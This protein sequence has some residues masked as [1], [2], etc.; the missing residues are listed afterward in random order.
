M[1]SLEDFKFAS[2]ERKCDVVT[3]EADYIMM[4]KL[5]NCKIYL[6]HTGEF[7]IEVY[8]SPVYKKVLM[9]NAFNDAAGLAPYTDNISLADLN[10]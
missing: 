2:F 6:Y 4:R 7:F 5:G 9:I 1:I 10:L 3:A 8:Y